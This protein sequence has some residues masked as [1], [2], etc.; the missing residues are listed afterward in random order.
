MTFASYHHP[1]WAA[2][3]AEA[4][5]TW[6]VQ[7]ELCYR[8][9]GVRFIGHGWRSSIDVRLQCFSNPVHC[10]PKFSWFAS[11]TGAKARCSAGYKDL[12]RAR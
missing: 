2:N 3:G 9:P 8:F 12:A 1:R 5:K 10:A 7:I 4:E 11:M 6:C